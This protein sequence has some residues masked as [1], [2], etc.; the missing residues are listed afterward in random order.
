MGAGH[1]FVG[2]SP[3]LLGEGNATLENKGL[4]ESIN[5]TSV[6]KPALIAPNLQVTDHIR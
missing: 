5:F 3:K 4:E 6:T 1:S 2:V